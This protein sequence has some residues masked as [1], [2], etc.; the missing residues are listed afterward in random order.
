VQSIE[1]NWYKHLLMETT[2][3]TSWVNEKAQ[4]RTVKYNENIKIQENTGHKQKYRKIQDSYKNTGIYKI[5]RTTG[6]TATLCSW[7]RNPRRWH[8]HLVQLKVQL[9]ILLHDRRTKQFLL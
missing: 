7:S 2:H 3:C 9:I 4:Q 5:Y 6:I 1:S 8:M